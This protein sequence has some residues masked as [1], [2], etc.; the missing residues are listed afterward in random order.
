[1]VA[2]VPLWSGATSSFTSSVTTAFARSSSSTSAIF[3]TGWPP[4]RTWLPGTSWPALSNT[5]LTRY[6]LPPPN[7][8]RAASAMAATSAA[9]TRILATLEPR[10]PLSGSRVLPSLFFESKRGQPTDA[11]HSSR[12]R[13][14]AAYC[15][16]LHAERPLRL[17]GQKLSHELVVGVEELGR[18]T[19]FD[20]PALPENRD[21]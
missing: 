5:A 13:A 2:V 6:E 19:R 12:A 20:D 18:R 7:M 9:V 14:P 11:S 4:T 3:P 17:P 15:V 8:A 1:M 21:V 16:L 10:S